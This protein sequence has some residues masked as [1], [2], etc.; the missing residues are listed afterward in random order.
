MELLILFHRLMREYAGEGG[1][2]QNR[3]RERGEG[4]GASVQLFPKISLDSWLSVS[5]PQKEG[6]INTPI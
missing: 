2:S 1:G 4:E 3:L 5:S 6:K